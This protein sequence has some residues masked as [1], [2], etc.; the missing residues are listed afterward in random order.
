[1]SRENVSLSDT[2]RSRAFGVSRENIPTAQANGIERGCLKS[3][4]ISLLLLRQLYTFHDDNRPITIT[5][6]FDI[7]RHGDS[8]ERIA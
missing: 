4:L 8:N 3:Q 7:F 2:E 5:S 1:M 6:P